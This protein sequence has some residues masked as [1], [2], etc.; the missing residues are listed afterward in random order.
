MFY[1]RYNDNCE[2]QKDYDNYYNHNE[3]KNCCLKRVEE[4]FVCFPSYYNEE[5]K[6]DCK[7]ED[8]NNFYPSYEGTFRIW[9]TN[10]YGNGKDDNENHCHHNENKCYRNRCCFCCGIFGKRW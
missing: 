9:P 2:N 10:A 1:N 6:E 5:K 4:T 7:K 8:N 3:R